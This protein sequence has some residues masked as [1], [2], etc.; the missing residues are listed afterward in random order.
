VSEDPREAAQ[1]APELREPEAPARRRRRAQWLLAIA[2]VVFVAL[3]G[4]TELR[5]RASREAL[6]TLE[7][8]MG[9][10]D[11]QV[12]RERLRDRLQ[13]RRSGTAVAGLVRVDMSQPDED[14][15]AKGRVF[16]DYAGD[17]VFGFFDG[18]DPSAGGMTYQL[19]FVPS[20]HPPQSIGR[21]SFGAHGDGVLA[22][23][24][25]SAEAIPGIF[26]LTLEPQG[27]AL[28]PSGP[29]ILRGS[30]DFDEEMDDEDA[31][32]E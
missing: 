20:G 8:E 25:I 16:V 17:R 1:P 32:A 19:W 21:V 29:E 10:L 28:M 12:R 5:L 11:G 13:T 15:G 23:S 27:G 30:L 7:A 24:E 22:A 31:D 3:W 14:D 6:H 9:V 26:R 4:W 18:L 2:A